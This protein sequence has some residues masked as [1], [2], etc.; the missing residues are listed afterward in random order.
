MYYLPNY[1]PTYLH[2]YPPTQWPFTCILPTYL[3]TFLWP[4]YLLAWIFTTYLLAYLPQI[5]FIWVKIWLV[6]T[7]NQMVHTLLIKK[8]TPIIL[9]MLKLVCPKWW[10]GLFD[11]CS[12]W[13]FFTRIANQK[14]PCFLIVFSCDCCS[15]LDHFISFVI[16]IWFQIPCKLYLYWFNYSFGCLWSRY[17]N[18]ILLP[19]D[20]SSRACQY[21]TLK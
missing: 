5:F 10:N 14:V 1:P 20:V 2:I 16:V 11:T 19:T 8:T 21:C 7:I 9:D 12:N 4:T 18:F 6:K 3:P 17:F 13:F 15:S